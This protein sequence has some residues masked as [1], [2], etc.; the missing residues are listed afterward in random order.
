M[1]KFL[2]NQKCTP[3]GIYKDEKETI[4]VTKRGFYWDVVELISRDLDV[5]RQV[6]PKCCLR[7]V[8]QPTTSVGL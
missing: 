2:R 5:A 6:Y 1:W 8:L 7:T 3:Q 4:K